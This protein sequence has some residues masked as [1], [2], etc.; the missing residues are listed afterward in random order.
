MESGRR[1]L[2]P[3]ILTAICGITGSIT[4]S[5]HISGGDRD[6][7][8]AWNTFLVILVVALVGL[9]VRQSRSRKVQQFPAFRFLDLRTW[10]SVN[11][12]TLD[13]LL[14]DRQT[15][16]HKTLEFE[17]EAGFSL[18]I[19]C[20][21]NGDGLVATLSSDLSHPGTFPQSAFCRLSSDVQTSISREISR[22]YGNAESYNMILGMHFIPAPV[23]RRHRIVF[24]SLKH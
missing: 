6:S 16:T 23:R 3:E 13:D 14:E 7:M 4:L 12:Q 9:A 8:E 15:F 17:S 18:L 22:F 11:P 19:D 21:S 10:A 20:K 24:K 5:R 1:N 2:A